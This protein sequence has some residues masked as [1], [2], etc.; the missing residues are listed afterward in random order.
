MPAKTGC[1][2]R[3]RT[4]AQLWWAVLVVGIAGATLFAALTIAHLFV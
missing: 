3:Q 4:R 2:C 1:C